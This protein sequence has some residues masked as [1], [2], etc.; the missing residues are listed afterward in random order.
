MRKDD[1]ENK[2][3]REDRRRKFNKKK[4]KQCNK[5]GIMRRDYSDENKRMEKKE[6][7]R[8]SK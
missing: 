4:M 2:E 3:Q 8:K 5:S 7:Q 1:K 6:T